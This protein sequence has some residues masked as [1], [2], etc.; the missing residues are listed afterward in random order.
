MQF[1]VA[2]SDLKTGLATVKDTVGKGD[3]GHM[4]VRVYASAK[5]NKIKLTTTDGSN[6]TETWVAGSVKKAGKGCINAKKFQQYISRLDAEKA[7][8]TLKDNGSIMLKS[9]RGQ[10]TF[11]G[12]DA[13][14]F[15]TPPKAKSQAKWNMA[16]RIFKQLVNGVSFAAGDNSNMPILEGINLISDGTYLEMT[17]TNTTL[18]AHYKKKVKAPE[19]NITLARKSL[20]NSAR[21]VKDDE[22]VSLQLC[23]DT[24]FIV[25]IDETS[26]HM[27]LL[28]GKYPALRDIIPKSDFPL[29]F[30]IER[31]EIIGVLDRATAMLDTKGILHFEKGK[32]ILSGK[33]EDSD[34][35]EYIM[36]KLQGDAKSVRVDLRRMLDVVKNIDAENITV[37]VRDREPLTLRPDS[38]QEQTC[39]LTIAA[40]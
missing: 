4:G 17:T 38:K 18:I 1:T 23:D 39:L 26:Y 27:P 37:G 8:L 32:V 40:S 10:Q 31:E 24:R 16:G 33:T 35:S 28:A 6:T 12:Y 19:M 22:K 13:E 34:F 20:I 5:T 7:T 9:Q 2:V 14:T 36:T 21:F 3:Q 11:S 29:E 25:K 30:T 15:N